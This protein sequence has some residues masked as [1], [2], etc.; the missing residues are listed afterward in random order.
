VGVATDLLV[1]GSIVVGWTLV[2][3]R[4]NRLSISAPFAFLIAGFILVR[5]DV[6]R[7]EP[8]ALQVLTEVTLVLLLFHDA[9]KVRVADVRLDAAFVARLLLVGLP[10]TIGAGWLGAK[11]LFPELGVGLTL[12]LAA[13]LAPTDAGLGAPTVLNPVV[14]ERIRRLL[15]VE[16]GLNDGLA[17]PVVLVAIAIAASDA[18]VE[19]PEVD[20]VLLSILIGVGEGVAVGWL[21]ALLISISRTREWSTESSRGLALAALPIV[22]YVL[23]GQTSG[24]GFIAAFVA[25]LAFAAAA[26]WLARDHGAED[27]LETSSD[28][29][30]F[31]VWFIVGGVVARSLGFMDDVRVWAFAL[32]ALT[33]FRMVPVWLSLLGTGLRPPSV[34]FIGWFGPRGLASVVFALL[35]IEELAAE[36]DVSPDLGLVLGTILLTVLLS[37]VA[38]GFSGG[39]LAERYGAWSSRARPPVETRPSAGG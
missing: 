33:A 22:A 25:G 13:A 9:S 30:G 14:P 8:S 15:N 11:L 39:P 38:H 5:W 20:R 4:A 6:T 7:L 37:V 24:N 19:G 28:L 26:P 18:G 34:L 12:L 35:A 36:G 1:F 21:G 32:L 16:S 23:A 3:R 29:T 10:L 17:T 27:F 2:S 31:A